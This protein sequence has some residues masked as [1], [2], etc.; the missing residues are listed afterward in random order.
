MDRSGEV[1]LVSQS[2]EYIA[3]TFI[4]ITEELYYASHVGPLCMQLTNTVL[5][6]EGK[7]R[8]VGK[9]IF[10]LLE[11]VS[12]VRFG[13]PLCSAFPFDYKQKHLK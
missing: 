7:K 4:S 11:P 13:R 1:A 9:T 6:G 10:S 5:E 2:D 8:E 3:F 12:L